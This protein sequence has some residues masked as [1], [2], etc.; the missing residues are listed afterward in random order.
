M[1]HVQYE[2]QD[3]KA[4]LANLNTRTEKHGPEQVP[5]A[6]LKIDCFRPSDDLAHFGPRLKSDFFNDKS[7]DLAGGPAIAHPELKGPHKLNCSMTGAEVRIEYGVKSPIILKDVKVNG[8]QFDPKEGGSIL[9]SFRVQCQPDDTQIGKLYKLQGRE[10]NVT[11]IPA[12]LPEV[13]DT[14]DKGKKD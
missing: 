6:D 2:L 10:I 1:P 5:A 12:E 3:A 4:I 11:I 8:F 13:A 7:L 14:G 9:L